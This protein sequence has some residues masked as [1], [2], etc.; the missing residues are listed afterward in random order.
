MLSLVELSR[1]VRALEARIA[2]HRVQA[3]VQPD[4]ARVVL[5]TYGPAEDPERRRHHVLLS[6]R[7][8]MARLA[9]LERPPRAPAPPPPFAQLLKSRALGA[10]VASVRLR[11]EDRLADLVFDTEDGDLHLLLS[12]FGRRSNLYLLDAGERVLAALRPLASTRS[13]LT[14]GEPWQLPASRPPRE[15]EDRFSAEPDA[16][17]L[18]A[19]EARYSRAE[20]RA[21]RDAL[22]RRIEQALR[23]GARRLDRKLEKLA[24]ELEEAQ[25]ATGCQRQGELLKGALSRVR[26]GDH[27][28]VVRD[29]ETGADVAIPLDPTL[30]PA[31]NL[32]RLFR[33]Y[34][35]AL[36]SL[37]KG[38]AREQE[39]Q[40]A[41]AELDALREEFEG[42]GGEPAEL[43][44][45]AARSALR[46]LLRTHAPA[47][48][49]A[50][51]G[52]R[53][54]P[55]RKLAGRSM[56]RRLEPRRYRTAA[57]LEI[58]VGRSAAGN[59]H[60]TTRLARGRDLF[61]H[62]EGSPGSHVLLRTGGRSDPPS[63]AVLDAC[64]LAVHF[65]RHKK[66][67]RADVHV[68]PIRNVRKPKG[69]KPGLVTV[70]G[71]KTVRLRRTPARLERI[72]AA[73]IDDPS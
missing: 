9:L 68:V 61:V 5:T 2:G 57:G 53:R 27:E 26:R 10:R 35:K 19:I 38:G 45:F 24:L 20:S 47:A 40:H 7:A 65:S 36:R 15:G 12:I 70:H 55:E 73:R 6:C 69:A 51:S 31:E 3:V 52:P 8:E 13:E 37:T 29:H 49:P 30:T 14:L 34:R 60:L 4:D 39:V 59:D 43:E 33:R 18:E 67:T 28:V 16:R 11:G 44:S 1:A 32:E 66:A 17:L 48:P 64:E 46:Q 25:R 54:A 56:P 71:G 42:G 72:L 22:A 41:R 63:E 58:W 21:D 50:R 62:L 23:K